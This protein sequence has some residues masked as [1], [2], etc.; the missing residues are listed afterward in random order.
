MESLEPDLGMFFFIAGSFQEVLGN[1]FV[2]FLLGYTG[3]IAIFIVCLGFTGK[4]S[5]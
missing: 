4:R 3:I 2:P 5:P 1:P